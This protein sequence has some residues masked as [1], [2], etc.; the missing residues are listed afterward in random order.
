MWQSHHLHG[1]ER[2]RERGNA[3]D[4]DLTVEESVVLITN[5]KLLPNNVKR[6][7]QLLLGHPSTFSSH[8]IHM[9]LIPN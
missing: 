2:G 8:L 9:F 6:G 7:F 5:N 1:N 4:R 3:A